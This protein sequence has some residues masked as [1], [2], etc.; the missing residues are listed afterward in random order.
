VSQHVYFVQAVGGGPIKI[1]HAANVAARV[2][3]LQTGS[4]APLRVLAVI[5]GAGVSAETSLHQRFA[6]LRA[7]GEWFHP[8]AELTDFIASLKVEDEG[9]LAGDPAALD[10][11]WALDSEWRVR[12]RHATRTDVLKWLRNRRVASALERDKQAAAK[13][14]EFMPDDFVTVEQAITARLAFTELATTSP[15]S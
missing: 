15:R 13:L 12:A 6:H 1:G 3:R 8:A 10:Q 5:L 7:H 4:P 9:L 11:I 2:D 14:L